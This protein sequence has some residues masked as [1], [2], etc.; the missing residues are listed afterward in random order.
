MIDQMQTL[1]DHLVFT[2][3]TI[4]TPQRTRVWNEKEILFL[5]ENMGY[6]TEAEIGAILGRPAMGVK[7]KRERIGLQATTKTPGWLSATQVRYKL[8][9]NDSRP[10]AGWVR[11][12]LLKGHI[13]GSPR[14]ICM[15]NELSLRQFVINPMNWPW[16]DLDKVEDP[17]YR[18]L[19][20]LQKERWSDEWLTAR[21]AREICGL[22]A[23]HINHYIRLGRLFSV[24]TYN[25]DGRENEKGCWAN[26]KVLRSQIENL[27]IWKRGEAL[28][29]CTSRAQDWIR[30]ALAN[31]WNAA[32]IGR[33]MK[34]SDQTVRNWIKKYNLATKK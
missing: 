1:I 9:M 10:I 16:F 2:A 31:G 4:H 21:Q 17:H 27:H 23:S 13:L 11:K 14:K 12:G 18:R 25:K 26:Y 3:D 32:A 19:L 30:F 5:S 28:S 24:H 7:L 29:S 15:V 6:L 20:E 8:G 22:E 33:S 34:R